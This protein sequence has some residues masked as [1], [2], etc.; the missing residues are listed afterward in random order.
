MTALNYTLYSA[1]C[2]W[3]GPGSL[4]SSRLPSGCFILSS[5]TEHR[6]PSLNLDFSCLVECKIEFY[7]VFSYSIFMVSS[8]TVIS[9]MNLLNVVWCH[10]PVVTAPGNWSRKTTVPN[11]GWSLVL[12]FPGGR[13]AAGWKAS[14]LTVPGPAEILPCSCPGLAPTTSSAVLPRNLHL[15]WWKWEIAFSRELHFI[16]WFKLN[17]FFIWNFIELW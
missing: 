11:S 8:V 3:T 4:A 9:F 17:W 13:A 5:Y 10:M 16:S 2:L 14:L 1:F 6:R 15:R 12:M 7:L